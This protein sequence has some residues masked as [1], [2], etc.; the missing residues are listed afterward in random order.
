MTKKNKFF[1]PHINTELY[2]NRQYTFPSEMT[3]KKLLFLQNLHVPTNISST[4]K[5]RKEISIYGF[6]I[7]WQYGIQIP[8]NT[9]IYRFSFIER[10]GKM[11]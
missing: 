4:K 5:Y 10:G 6:A 7:V 2:T 1:T 9:S 8:R 11:Y 3:G